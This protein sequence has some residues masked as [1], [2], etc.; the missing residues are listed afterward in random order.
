LKQNR[1]TD[2]NIATY[3]FQIAS[4]YYYEGSDLDRI[5]S[6]TALNM[7]ELKTSSNANISKFID[8]VISN[9]AN[10]IENINFV[11]SKKTIDKLR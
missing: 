5:I 3:N 11:S 1:L 8:F 6:Y 7:I 4:N 9:G 10:P 2:E